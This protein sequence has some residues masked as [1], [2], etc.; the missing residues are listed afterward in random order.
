MD[1]LIGTVSK[2]I[3]FNEA[4]NLLKLTKNIELSFEFIKIIPIFIDK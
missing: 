4:N 2:I 1:T 3:I